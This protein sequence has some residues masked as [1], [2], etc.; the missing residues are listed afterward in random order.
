MILNI[1][2]TYLVGAE[3]PDSGRR[4][5]MESTLLTE[6][7]PQLCTALIGGMTLGEWGLKLRQTKVP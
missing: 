3:D 6:S 5:C 2:I 4:V 7:H 1:T